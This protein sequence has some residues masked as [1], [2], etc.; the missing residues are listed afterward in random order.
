MKSKLF[1]A[2]APRTTDHPVDGFGTIKLRELTVAENDAIAAKVKA[3]GEAAGSSELGLQLLL[4]SAVNDD[5]TPM[6]TEAEDLPELRKSAGQRVQTLVLKVL[7]I[8]GHKGG[9]QRVAAKNDSA[10]TATGA[11]ASA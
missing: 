6:L 11:S 7:E 5:G 1:A 4:A 10:P 9:E 2:L 3:M 8:N